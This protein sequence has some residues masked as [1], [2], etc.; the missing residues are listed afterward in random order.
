MLRKPVDEM[1]PIDMRDLSPFLTDRSIASVAHD[2]SGVRVS[3]DNGTAS[4]FHGIWLRDNCACPACR[5][6]QTLER[7][8]K[9]IDHPTAAAVAHV[10][11]SPAGGLTVDFG[12]TGLE[13]HESQF[14]AGWL[15]HHRYGKGVERVPEIKH[16]L[17]AQS[18]IQNIPAFPFAAV[19]QD[20]AALDAWLAA[21]IDW[22]V[23][24]IEH[25][26]TSKGTVQQLAER[27]GPLRPTN[28]GLLFEVEPKPNPNNSAYTA[29][30]LEPHT[31]I[32]NVPY[33][34]GI[35][36]LHCLQNDA[37]GGGSILVDGFRVAEELRALS[38]VDFKLLAEH[39]IEF[40]FH[41]SEVDLR[42]RAPVLKVDQNDQVIEVRF[43]NWLRSTLDLPADV[44]EGYYRA[45]IHYWSLL[46]EP[47]FQLRPRLMAGQ[48]VVF[49]NDRVLH[50][51][52][53]FDPSSG[54]RLLQGCYLDHETVLSR[55]RVLARRS[56][57]RHAG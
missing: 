19:M 55:R 52:E 43:S 31:D 23:T 39:A 30:G 25:M 37:R 12:G 22:G 48:A 27:V 46:R 51:R 8:F 13:G 1:A 24:L 56:D 44:V 38:A 26:P 21:L 15:W 17:W 47:R 18:D 10:G 14:T 32:P 40:R 5:H 2:A 6:S 42:H 3:W 45:L 29:L 49:D 33:P 35:Q 20:D 41:D 9:L 34:P 36:L 7:V 11:V 50:G 16:R 57:T 53:A 4:Q 54:A 28:F